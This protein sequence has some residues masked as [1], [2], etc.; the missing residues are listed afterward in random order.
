MLGVAAL[1]VGAGALIGHDL[2]PYWPAQ[3]NIASQVFLGATIGSKMNK[4]MFVGL[5][6]R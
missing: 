5:K 6:T 3:A 1:Q 4:Q 2:I